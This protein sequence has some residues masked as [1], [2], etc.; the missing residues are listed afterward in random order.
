M[1]SIVPN[2]LPK[3][4]RRLALAA[5]AFGIVA[6]TSLHA[7]PYANVVI[8]PPA[9]PPESARQ[10][11][12]ALLLRGARDGRQLLYIE[13]KDGLQLS[14]FDVT[15][16][17]HVRDMGSVK[18][19]VSGAF[20][21]ISPIGEHAELVRFRKNHDEAVMNFRRDVPNLDITSGLTTPVQELPLH[22]DG[23]SEV[24]SVRTGT[25]FHLTR[26]GLYL[27][28]RPDVESD[29]KQREQQWFEE[30]TGG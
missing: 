6:A 21:F 17:M 12:D 7:D 2:M 10:G 26:G 22:S 4:S 27:I 18:L 24:T 15:D 16:P 19:E 29:I 1:S 9:N 14:T 30:H 23:S 25:T 11:G 13:Q 5:A 8:V 3:F 28:R 20:D